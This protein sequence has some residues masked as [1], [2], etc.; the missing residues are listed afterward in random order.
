MAVTANQLIVA[1]SP[2]GLQKGLVAASTTLYQGTLAFSIAASGYID[3]DIAA[4]ANHFMGIVKEKADNSSGAAGDI[5]VELY[6]TG[7]FQMEGSGFTQALVGDKIYAVD[8]FTVNTTSASQ[9]LVGRC[10]EFI[11]STKIMVKIEVGVQ[12]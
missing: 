9:T 12:A 8:N 3:D 10:V 2:G 4:G 6:T 7:V 1:Q 11:S 5:D